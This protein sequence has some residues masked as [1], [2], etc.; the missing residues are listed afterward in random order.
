MFHRTAPA[1]GWYKAPRVEL[2]ILNKHGSSSDRGIINFMGFQN[3]PIATRVLGKQYILT[4]LEHSHLKTV[5][6]Y[7]HFLN[8]TIST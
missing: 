3:C 6:L 1:I 4:I 5:T 2:N 8:R 7:N